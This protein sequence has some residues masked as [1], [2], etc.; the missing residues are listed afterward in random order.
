V[1]VL[2]ADDDPV[3]ARM[4][5]AMLDKWG[6]TVWSCVD[7]DQ[8]WRLLQDANAP[9]LAILDWMMPHLDGVQVCQKLRALP[10]VQPTYIILLTAK[11]HSTDIAAGLDAGADDYVTK[12]FDQEELRARVQVGVRIVR[13]Q[14]SLAERV[15][16]LEAALARVKQ[17]RGL[18]P[19][20]SYCKK[21]RND[22]NYW[23][24]VD[25]YI[26]EHSDAQFSHSICPGCY[27][28]IVQPELARTKGVQ[29]DTNTPA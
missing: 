13:L 26:A 16:E 22:H 12:P 5:E 6:F 3:A 29:P 14:Q 18:L 9:R 17:L 25:M 24:Q 11:G 2:V 10:A 21:I 20:C 15:Q 23:E 19:I 4:L 8:A 28:R 1:K 7:G 27:E